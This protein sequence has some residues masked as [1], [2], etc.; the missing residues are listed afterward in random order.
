MT[1]SRPSLKPSIFTVFAIAQVL[2]FHLTLLESQT[3]NLARVNEAVVRLEELLKEE[4]Q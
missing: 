4:D 2:A 1:R 3:R